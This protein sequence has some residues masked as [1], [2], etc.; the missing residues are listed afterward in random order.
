MNPSGSFPERYPS[1]TDLY[2]KVGD[3]YEHPLWFYGGEKGMI[4]AIEEYTG[5]FPFISHIFTFPANTKSGRTKM[6]IERW[7][8]Y[9]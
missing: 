9:R 2:Y 8:M 4:L 1:M 3:I 5:P 6:S 7:E